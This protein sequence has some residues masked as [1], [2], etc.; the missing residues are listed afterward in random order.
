MSTAHTPIHRRTGLR[1]LRQALIALGVLLLTAI[2][3]AL[4]IDR[5]FFRNSSGPAAG[6]GSGVAA[7]QTRSVRPFGGVDLVGANNVIVRVGAR[8]SIIVHGDSNLLGRV[9]TRVREGRLVIGTTPGNLTARS[10]MFV[11]VSVPSLDGL[12]LQGAGNIS[13]TGINGGKLTVALP[14]S[15]NIEAAGTTAR[16]DVAISG[17]GTAQLR[18]LIAR[19]ARAVIGGDGTIMLTATHRLTARIS[20]HGTVLYTGDPPHVTQTVTGSGTISP[21]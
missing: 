3:L 18:Q 17:E 7:T 20:G 19:D 16:L 11:A 14:G 10:P 15:G 5:I 8:Q 4:V 2:L 1:R 6:T 13:V 21:G 12:R 9:T